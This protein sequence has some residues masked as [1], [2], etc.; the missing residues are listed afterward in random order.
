MTS[1][2]R[3]RWERASPYLDRAMGMGKEERAAWLA[4]LRA[5]TPELA[6]DIAA[7]LAERSAASREGFLEGTAA[8]PPAPASLAGQTF[9]A[10][11]LLSQVG[12]GGMGSVWL[13]DRS[14]GRF[15]GLAAVKL[16]NA[17]LVG[18]AGE[19]RFRREGN[20]LARL[21][22]PNI[23][24]MVDAGV[25]PSGQPYLVL[26]HVQGDPIDRYC[27]EQHLDVEARLR[28]FLDVLSAVAHAHANLIVHRDIKPSN[29]LVRTDGGVKLLDFGIA[30][31]LEDEA[32]AGETTA[33][34]REGGRVLTP[35][36][37]APEQVSGGM[38]TTATD[39]YSLGVLLYVLLSGQH[40]VGLG[41][42]PAELVKAVVESQPL[43]LSEAV[44]STKTSPRETLASN[45]SKRATTPERLSRLLRGDLENIV[46]KALKK[47][48]PE[49]YGSVAGL[50]DDLTRYLNHEPVSARPDSFLYRARKFVRRHRAGVAAATLGAVAVLTASAIAVVQ[51][52]EAHRQR[53]AAVLEA[54]RASA[55]SE[56]AR[57]VIGDN[58]EE[59]PVD[60]TRRRLDRA[61]SLLHGSLIDDPRIRTHLLLELVPRYMELGDVK[62]REEL[63][64]EAKE[65]LRSF[66]DPNLTA[67]LACLEGSIH[68]DEGRMDEASKEIANGLRR[69]ETAPKTESSWPDCLLADAYLAIRTGRSEHAVERSASAVGWIEQRGM[70]YS[71]TYADAL[72]SL[73]AAANASGQ[74][75]R[76]LDAI[77]KSIDLQRQIAGEASTG[78][79]VSTNGEASILR[80][81]G[82]VIE[83]R[84]VLDRLATDWTQHRGASSIPDF[85]LSAEGRVAWS[86]STHDQAIALLKRSVEQSES[87]GR[88]AP[89][90]DTRIY[91]VG[92]LT[93]AGRL[94]E[95][96]GLLGT[97]EQ[98]PGAASLTQ[99]QAG[100][101]ASLA[102]ARLLAAKKDFEAA[103]KSA[104]ET[105]DAIA[106]R[107]QANDPRVREASV[108]ASE[109]ALARNDFEKASHFAT[110]ALDRARKEAI[111]PR[112]SA[113][114][115]QA[116][117]LRARCEI[118]LGDVASASADSAQATSHLVA[119]LGE[120]HPLARQA[121]DISVKRH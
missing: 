107:G 91:L 63:I 81:G 54:K 15:E 6:A 20:I 68:A 37:A 118:A 116:L 83:A 52:V 92:A 95:A 61:R 72:H 62:V 38:I 121:R 34:T 36:Y 98:N 1:L 85:V 93:D 17:S 112:S 77:L 104:Q 71:T 10:Y 53:D 23:A 56:L 103:A 60:V 119:N 40:P 94:D 106:S 24:R 66:D 55:S 109:V 30:K 87:S 57:F 113:W 111:D 117:L 114:I 39:V 99:G 35:E 41:R 16:L 48:P 31:L 12:Q 80:A 65:S 13:A 74:Y 97:V 73:A 44:V 47:S 32:G 120:G 45:A 3:E 50:A 42:S 18:R 5:T 28:L 21:A 19:E 8:Y 49:R 110:A 105:L 46:G 69:L 27:D 51:M 86:L 58:S 115:G 100:I 78:V 88:V 67:V 14:D 76:A 101:S 70:R 82:K 64:Q 26:E 4:S 11:T 2:D 96:D 25:S 84:D 79:F 43:R 90:L 89:A 9:G 22:H 29:V 7:L 33:L 108:V 75:R 59:A 102:K